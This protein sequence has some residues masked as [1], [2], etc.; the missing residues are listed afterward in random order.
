MPG[1]L[2]KNRV[3][4]PKLVKEYML[5]YMSKLEEYRAKL[6]TSNTITP[7]N[8]KDI[9][10]FLDEYCIGKNLALPSQLKHIK[11]L[12]QLATVLGC[13]FRQVMAN[14]DRAAII[15]VISR[16]SRM[17]INEHIIYFGDRKKKVT[18]GIRYYSPA[19]MNE[20][21]KE[22][23]CFYRWLNDG[24]QVPICVKHI[25]LGKKPEKE[26]LPTQLI[27]NEEYQRI[28]NG[29][30]T[31]SDRAMFA[32]HLESG[33]RSGEFV[34][35][36]LSFVTFSGVG[37]KLNTADGKTGPRRVFLV[38]CVPYLRQWLNI[39]P[40]KD[41]LENYLWITESV[42]R[43]ADL[44]NFHNRHVRRLRAVCTRVGIS[45]HIWFHL[46]R[47]SQTT[48]MLK[49]K[50]PEKI[51]EKQMG[52]KPG[53]TMLNRYLH[54]AEEDTDNAIAEQYGITTG[55][56]EQEMGPVCP[57]CN[58]INPPRIK[59]FCGMCGAVL[60]ITAAHDVEQKMQYAKIGTHLLDKLMQSKRVRR[61][62]DELINKGELKEDELPQQ[63]NT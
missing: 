48:I 54:L 2:D 31:I 10:N 62:V 42:N 23:R 22:L 40:G 25:K 58:Y 39:H 1:L 45:K 56:K 29:A 17:N 36:R 50:V 19:T 57:V 61:M 46:G 35:M 7:N 15:G 12:M 27:T 13:D 59:D 55:Q 43:P 53:S 3:E 21:R 24:E 34:P 5:D 63:Q 44:L 16:L 52:W 20:F 18:P 47:H 32:V 8:K 38:A 14:N 37:Y 9:E 11:T 41:N 51:I 49:R 6:R 30:E 33:M 4:A 26:I 28:V 60:T